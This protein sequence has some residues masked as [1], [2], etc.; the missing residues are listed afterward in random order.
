MGEIRFLRLW[1][2]KHFPYFCGTP[3]YIG[4]VGGGVSPLP[5]FADSRGVGVSVMPTSAISDS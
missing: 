1:R 4:V 3:L 5:K 2:K